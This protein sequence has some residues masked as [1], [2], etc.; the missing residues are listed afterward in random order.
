M[1]FELHL[2]PKFNRKTGH[3]YAGH[4]PWNKGKKMKDWMDGRKIKRVLSYLELGRKAGNKD[5]PGRNKI[6]IVG[7]LDGK[8]YPFKSSVDAEQQLRADGIKVNARNIRAV[9]LGTVDKLGYVRKK[10]GGFM[11]FPAKDVKKYKDLVK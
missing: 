5:L 3:F 9:C 1:E 2:E 6:E 4:I 10:A 7:I 11:W 8:L